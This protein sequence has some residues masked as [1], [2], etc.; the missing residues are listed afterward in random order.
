MK[1]IKGLAILSFFSVLLGS[2]FDPPEFPAQPEIGFQEIIFKDVVD[3]RDPDTLILTITFKDGD[4]DLG[5]DPENP[6]HLTTPYNNSDYFQTNSTG[7]LLP[8]S[9]DVG[10]VTGDDG[11]GRFVELLDVA[12][13]TIGTFAFFS[14]R[15]D[16]NYASVLPDFTCT[17]YDYREFVILASDSLALGEFTSIEDTLTSQGSNDIYY[18]V[19]DSLYAVLNPNHYNIEVDF[20]VKEG[21][22]FVEFDWRKEF[23]T[24]FDG[25]FPIL[26]DSRNALDGTLKYNMESRGFKILFGNKTLKLRIQIKDRALNRSNIVESGEFTLEG[27]RK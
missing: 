17:D 6:E 1:V 13:P 10:E 16:P 22:T 5:L 23:C 9:V 7:E 18:L 20:L 15:R 25:R 8:I 21:S 27:I 11:N 24:T 2:C 3:N 14:N 12:D 26:S 19:K 4:G